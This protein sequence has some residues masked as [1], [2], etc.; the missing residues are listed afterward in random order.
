MVLAKAMCLY[1]MPDVEFILHPFDTKKVSSKTKSVVFSF[2]KDHTKDDDI[3]IPYQ[4]F[5][6][7][8]L[9]GPSF[10]DNANISWNDRDD[11]AVWRGSTTGGTYTEHSWDLLPRSR[12]SLLCKERPDLCDAGFT[13]VVPHSTV[14]A[15]K[16]MRAVLGIKDRVSMPDMARWV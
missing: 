11:K 15:Q 2:A 4:S 14:Q 6:W 8:Y 16:V 12:I 7:P 9:H 13:S 10:G 1:K 3:L 5:L